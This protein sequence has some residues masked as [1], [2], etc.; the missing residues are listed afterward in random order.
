MT[1]ALVVIALLTLGYFV[2]RDLITPRNAAIVV[3]VCLIVW[4]LT[5]GADL[6]DLRR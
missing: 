5:G 1:S 4:L 6:V 3:A 2:L